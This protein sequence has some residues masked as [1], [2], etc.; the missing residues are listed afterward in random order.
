MYAKY[1][2]YIQSNP[3]KRINSG[4]PILMLIPRLILLPGTH[5]TLIQTKSCLNRGQNAYFQ[6][7]MF[8]PPAIVRG[9]T[10]LS[11]TCI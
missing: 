1:S 8:G 2:T 6:G 9:S 4:T 11:P 3:H 5:I 10:I 7:Q